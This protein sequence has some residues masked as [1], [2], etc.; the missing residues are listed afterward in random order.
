[1]SGKP[2]ELRIDNAAEFENKALRRGCEQH[3]IRLHYRPPGQPY[4]AGVVDWQKTT[5]S[6]SSSAKPGER[7]AKSPCG[8][9][10]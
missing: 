7:E 3:G 9:S 6:A 2:L 4:F 1:M 5:A 8:N 10:R